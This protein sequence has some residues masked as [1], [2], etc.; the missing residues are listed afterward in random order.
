M[1]SFLEACLLAVFF[2]SFVLFCSVF[3]PLSAL[4][5]LSAE[6]PRPPPSWAPSPKP[7][8]FLSV[9]ESQHVVR[10]RHVPGVVLNIVTWDSRTALSHSD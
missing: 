3:F 8:L 9:T 5:F 1:S 6:A 2:S 4:S 10:A 7:V